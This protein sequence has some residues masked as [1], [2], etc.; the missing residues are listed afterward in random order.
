M[1]V[2]TV[3]FALLNMKKKINLFIFSIK[4]IL[5]SFMFESQI[6]LKKPSYSC[7]KNF[8]LFIS[9]PNH[10]EDILIFFP[11]FIV[12]HC[13]LRDWKSFKVD[14]RTSGCS[15]T[16]SLQIFVVTIFRIATIL[17]IAVE[18]KLRKKWNA[19]ERFGICKLVA[20]IKGWNLQDRIQ[21]LFGFS[22]SGKSSA[23]CYCPLKFSSI[24]WFERRT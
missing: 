23:Q 3:Q 20:N 8:V 10:N 18:M 6:R 4:L 7:H 2:V 11:L 9:Y 5:R 22:P 1:S 24:A 14:P 15:D 21:A 12:H 17:G 13:V 16:G 19:Q